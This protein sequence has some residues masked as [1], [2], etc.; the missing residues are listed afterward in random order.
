MRKP[1]FQI[2]EDVKLYLGDCREVLP[3]IPDASADIVLTSPPYNIGLNYR[4]YDDRLPDE[5][6]ASMNQEWLAE[7]LRLAS[8][9]CRLYAVVMDSVGW[10]FKP[11]AEAVGWKYVQRLTWCKNNLCGTTK[12]ISGEWNRLSEDILLFR[13]GKRTPMLNT[14]VGALTFNWFVFSTP[15]SNFGGE[16]K[17]RHVA[18]WPIGLPHLLIGRTPGA[19]V[20]DPFMGAGTGGVA[21]VRLKRRFIG[22]DISPDSFDIAVERIRNAY[23]GGPLL[24]QAAKEPGKLPGM[25][26]EGTDA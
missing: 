14:L 21:A 20:V 5:E 16:N 4:G 26:E 24:E 2:G 3:E 8:D 6:Y 23:H 9:G 18:Q 13:H 19:L 1:D 10:L 25:K 15:Q 11:W 7:V 22:I 12:K 17:R